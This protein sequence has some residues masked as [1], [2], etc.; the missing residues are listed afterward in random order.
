MTE[1]ITVNDVEPLRSNLASYRQA[2]SPDAESV[3]I[4]F[5]LSPKRL[6]GLDLPC[7]AHSP[8]IS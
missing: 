4:A 1:S 6:H 7:W 2:Q 8:F 5:A 3:W